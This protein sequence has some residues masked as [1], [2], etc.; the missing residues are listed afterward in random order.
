MG[1]IIGI[2][3]KKMETTILIAAPSL[4]VFRTIHPAWSP[5]SVSELK[6]RSIRDRAPRAVESLKCFSLICCTLAQE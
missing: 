3:E 5:E 2:M 1:V 6:G 4:E